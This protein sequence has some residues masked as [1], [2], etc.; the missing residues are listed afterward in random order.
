MPV[1]LRTKGN[2]IFHW[3]CLFS[4]MGWAAEGQAV[5]CTGNRKLLDTPWTATQTLKQA[6]FC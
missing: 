1:R 3:A 6:W 2:G 4:D 5:A